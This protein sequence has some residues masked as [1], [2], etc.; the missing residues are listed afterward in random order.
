MRAAIAVAFVLALAACSRQAPATA[1]EAKAAPA[2]SPDTVTLDEAAQ[3]SAGIRVEPAVERAM[4]E[5]VRANA[6]ITNDEERTWRVGAITDGRVV[7]VLVAPG[8]TVKEGQPLARLHS[9]EIHDSRAQYRNAVS[10]F[11]RAKAAV[12]YAVKARD[13]ARRLLELKAASQQELEHAENDVRNAEAAQTNAT[14]EV[15]RHR[16]HLEEFLGIP[17]EDDGHD[18]EHDLIP[19]R[20]PASGTVLVRNVT[21]GAVVTPAHDMFVISNLQSLWAIAEVNE[22]HLRKLRPGMPVRVSVQAWD[23]EP[24]V[25]RIAKLGESLDPQ[26]RTVKV[27]VAVPNQAGRLKPEMYANAEIDVGASR[28]AIFIATETTQEIRGEM[29]VFVRTTPTKFEAR[30]VDTGRTIDRSVE[31][32][33]GLRPGELV[34][35]SGAFILKSEYLKASLADE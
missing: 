18:D 12:A 26:T 24:F 25:G 20:A 13:R 1:T 10:E 30:H 11:Q 7:S 17:A 19:V 8:D 16:A 31:I 4:P 35:V 2:K 21:Q 9:H 28:Q 29:V 6:R 33:R 34:A 3:R 23:K 15:A 14:N 27:R 22:E 5:V 32:V